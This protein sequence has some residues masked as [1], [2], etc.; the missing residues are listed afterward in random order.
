MLLRERGAFPRAHTLIAHPF[1]CL[2]LGCLAVLVQGILPCEAQRPPQSLPCDYVL[3]PQTDPGGCVSMLNPVCDESLGGLPCC[4]HF[5]L[6]LTWNQAVR[7]VKPTGLTRGP[8]VKRYYTAIDSGCVDRVCVAGAAWTDYLHFI[9][10]DTV[11]GC[12]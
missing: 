1:R 10:E 2:I 5:H 9:W 7:W 8:P 11:V 6:P 3:L 4:A 12:P